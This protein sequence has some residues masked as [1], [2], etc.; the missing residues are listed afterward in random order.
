ME[1][2]HG[3]GNEIAQNRNKKE[4][5]DISNENMGGKNL[6]D[7]YI[8]GSGGSIRL[9]QEDIELMKKYNIPIIEIDREKYIELAQKSQQKTDETE[10]IEER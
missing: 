2:W 3:R 10:K 8:S 9:N 7:A 6:P 4:L 5:K 1:L